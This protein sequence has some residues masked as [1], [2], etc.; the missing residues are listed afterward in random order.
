MRLRAA[1]MGK[2]IRVTVRCGNAHSCR[3]QLVL[4]SQRAHVALAGLPVKVGPGHERT[5][6]M[7]LTG[8]PSAVLWKGA[9]LRVQVSV[10]RERRGRLVRRGHVLVIVGRHPRPP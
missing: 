1:W 3:G 5:V 7:R 8:L 2:R 9:R 4:R 10:Q 6:V